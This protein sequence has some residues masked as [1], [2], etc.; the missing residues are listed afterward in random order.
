MEPPKV[1]IPWDIADVNV[2][3]VEVGSSEAIHIT[4]ESTLNYAYCRSGPRCP[5]IPPP[6]PDTPRIHDYVADRSTI[7]YILLRM[8]PPCVALPDRFI[9]VRLIHI[10][11][12]AS[13]WQS[14]QSYLRLVV[15]E[16][17]RSF[18]TTGEQNGLSSFGQIRPQSE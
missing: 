18:S 9:W 15:R 11:P 10:N 2:L 7:C 13:L 4:V 3:G 8:F 1:L 14:T 17:A 12:S 5:P 16:H 6:E